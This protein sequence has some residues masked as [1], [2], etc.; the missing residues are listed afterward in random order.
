MGD[1]DVQ[2][3]V[4]VQHSPASVQAA[5]PYGNSHIATVLPGEPQAEGE[6]FRTPRFAANSEENRAAFR[7]LMPLS[8]SD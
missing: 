5:E 1:N 3:M 8:T 6:R 2:C 7:F 4:D